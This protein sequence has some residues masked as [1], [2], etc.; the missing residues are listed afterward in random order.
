MKSKP[1]TDEQLIDL[2]DKSL[3]DFQRDRNLDSAAWIQSHPE[4]DETG[5]G[6]VE[7]LL[8]LSA[9]IETWKSTSPMLNLPD[10]TDLMN[11]TLVYAASPTLIGRY[12]ILEHV[13]SG[14]M[15]DVFRAHDP[16][17]DRTVAV[18]IPRWER[19][20]QDPE[21]Y[22]ERFLRE[23]RAAAKVRHAHVCPL[24]DAGTHDGQ[25]YVVMAFV[26]GASLD[27]MLKKGRIED[28]PTAVRIAMEVAEA[29][30]EVHRHGIIH[31]DLKPGN[32]LI[33]REGLASLTDFGLAL[34]T[35]NAERLTSDGMVVGTPVYMSPEQ[36]AGENT[37]LTPSADIYSL[38]AV[39]YE[40]LV[41]Q[42]PF[43]APLRELLLKIVSQ[44]PA[45]PLDH[46]PELDP[47]LAA[48]VMRAL[49]KSPKQRFATADDLAQSLRDW[50]DT[51][52]LKSTCVAKPRADS[53][54]PRR[55][56]MRVALLT[57]LI[58]IGVMAAISIPIFIN[59][60]DK[61][62]GSV[63]EYHLVQPETVPSS[64]EANAIQQP[65]RQPLQGKISITISSD[66]Q[67]GA[68]EK[69]KRPADEPGALP[70]LTGELVQ[71]EAQLNQPAFI[72]LLWV[73][74]DGSVVPISPWDI[75]NQVGWDA[76]PVPGSDR[77]RD[78][79]MCPVNDGAGFETIAPAG[80]QT[81]VLLARRQPLE[82]SVSL[83]NLLARL[84]AAPDVDVAL[85][86]AQAR[87]RGLKPGQTKS[88][89]DPLFRELE[90]R[91]RPHFEL[92]RILSFPQVDQLPD[93]ATR[94][95]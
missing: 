87:T 28:V 42:P 80:L 56:P 26:D 29:L 68:V 20:T 31:R 21:I 89:D 93:H 25:P 27:G 83:E 7:T 39:L 78:R 4:L 59:H 22:R 45:S 92:V 15:G 52:S 65:G 37:T 55:G 62:F 13:G 53:E 64:L 48:I 57:G 84:P 91:L 16:Q 2:L 47:Q 17:L 41:G 30:A 77:P 14:A 79:V 3:R 66:P 51:E 5:S 70:I 35:L 32:I 36:A 82:S 86:D 49:E 61:A 75:E 38:G 54:Q 72:Y 63:S 81:L 40:M 9:S 8:Q 95:R 10:G 90:T 69:H 33:D 50:L 24:Y 6:L 94:R 34:S 43:L 12:Q 58:V 88:I 76:T 85:A 74:P 19:L 67:K 71:F 23:A 73:N 1:L 60:G 46:R 18:K 11:A 44:A